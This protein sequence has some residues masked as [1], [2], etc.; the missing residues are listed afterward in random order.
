MFSV[1]FTKNEIDY[2][3]AF[4]QEGVITIRSKRGQAD[5]KTVTIAKNSLPGQTGSERTLAGRATERGANEKVAFVW[6]IA[7]NA[8][9]VPSGSQEISNAAAGEKLLEALASFHSDNELSEE[10]AAAVEE[11]I[12]SASDPN[13]MKRILPMAIDLMI[14]C[15]QND[16]VKNLAK[17]IFHQASLTPIAHLDMASAL[18]SALPKTNDHQVKN[19]LLQALVSLLQQPN[20]NPDAHENIAWDLSEALSKA[21]DPQ[22]ITELGNA[23]IALSNHPNLNPAAH[24]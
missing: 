18:I 14:S 15:P 3:I 4:P 8:S 2:S 17:A 21:S 24:G 5:Q 23:I 9:E 20:L 19:D 13:L 22:V 6:A 16:R 7:Q 10:L 12:R 11:L 1:N